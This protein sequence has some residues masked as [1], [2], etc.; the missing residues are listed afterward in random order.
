MGVLNNGYMIGKGMGFTEKDRLCIP[1]PFYHCFGMVLSNMACASNG[2]TMV[3]PAPAF[4]PEEV[5]KTIEAER[6]T[7]V[8]GVPYDVHR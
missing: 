2:A 7:A 6:C 8:H 5:L 1:V 4:D 3:I